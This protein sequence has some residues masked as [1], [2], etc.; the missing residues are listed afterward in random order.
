MRASKP[1]KNTTTCIATYGLTSSRLQLNQLITRYLNNGP[2]QEHVEQN[3][4]HKQPCIK[5]LNEMRE[6]EKKY[7]GKV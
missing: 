7:S 5:H 6:M 3:A 1:Y 4:S 2:L